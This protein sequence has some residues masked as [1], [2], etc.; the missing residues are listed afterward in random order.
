M[1]WRTTCVHMKCA[2]IA[3]VHKMS[4]K[5]HTR[6]ARTYHENRPPAARPSSLARPP[7]HLPPQKSNPEPRGKHNNQPTMTG[8]GRG[9]P[10]LS[11]PPNRT[12]ITANNIATVLAAAGYVV[13]AA[14]SP[15]DECRQT[16]WRTRTST[17]FRPS[18]KNTAS[19]QPATARTEQRRNNKLRYWCG[20][21]KLGAV[22]YSEE[23]KKSKQEINN[24]QTIEPSEPSQKTQQNNHTTINQHKSK[25]TQQYTNS[26]QQLRIDNTIK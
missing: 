8:V 14:L 20:W 12:K 13:P 10:P 11:R 1:T 15:Q 9:V 23:M 25:Q 4:S 7:T 5:M 18:E 6:N 24:K 3:R 16:E 2:R 17:T 26:T 22:F 19:I 21:G